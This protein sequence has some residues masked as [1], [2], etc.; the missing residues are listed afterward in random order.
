MFHF[1]DEMQDGVLTTVGG[2]YR[3]RPEGG[4]G[5]DNLR[6][7][8]GT[9]RAGRDG[10]FVGGIDP[11]GGTAHRSLD[12]FRGERYKLTRATCDKGISMFMPKCL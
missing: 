7:H 1:D 10:N 9:V 5:K 3:D 11:V 6:D 4:A 2:A 12:G 8:D